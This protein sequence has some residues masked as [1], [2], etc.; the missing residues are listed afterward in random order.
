MKR[1]DVFAWRWHDGHLMLQS[2]VPY[3]CKSCIAIFDGVLLRDTYWASGGDVLH[4]EQVE[5]VYL[6]NLDDYDPVDI[7]E[8][9][10]V[11]ATSGL[12]DLRHPNGGRCY[13]KKGTRPHVPTQ[14][15][16]AV[17][18]L[19]KAQER[20]SMLVRRIIELTEDK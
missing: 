13:L 11:Y 9:E 18:L 12:L 6:G 4:P 7:D 19:S 2:V 5:L 20:V 8:P 15:A 14:L 1:N 17:Q 3:W 10:H 16:R